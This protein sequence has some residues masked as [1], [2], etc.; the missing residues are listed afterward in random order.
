MLQ[1]A[2]GKFLESYN[3]YKWPYKWVTWG[4]F[5]PSYRSYFTLLIAIVGAHLVAKLRNFIFRC[6]ITLAPPIGFMVEY[7]VCLPI[8]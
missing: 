4:Y 8:L 7:S 5:T 3:P 6:W 2:V 1:G